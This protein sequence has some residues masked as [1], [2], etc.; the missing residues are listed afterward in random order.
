MRRLE[1]IDFRNY[2]HLRLDLPDAPV[3]L[4]GA[5]GA[6]KTNL[7]EALSLFSPGRGLRRVLLREL[8][9][10][11]AEAGWTLSMRLQT[12]TGEVRLGTGLA[13]VD[14]R[15]TRV[16]RCDG[17]KLSAQG[18]AE[19]VGLQWLTP[20]MDRLFIEG[21]APRR[22]YLDRLVLAF[23][24][25]HGRRVASYERGLRERAR[26]ARSGPAD[27]TWLKVLEERMAGDA[28]AI[29]AARRDAVAR[30]GAELERAH[31]PF[32]GAVLEAR[33]TIE[34]W[35]DQMAAVDAEARFQDSLAAERARGAEHAHAADG[36]QRS[37]LAVYHA[38]KGVTAAQC[39]TGEQKA[40]LIAIQLAT[41]RLERRRRGQPPILLFDEIAAHLDAERRAALFDSLFTLGGQVWMTGTDAELFAPLAGRAVFGRVD[42]G[43]IELDDLRY[44][45][46]QTSQFGQTDGTWRTESFE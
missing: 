12:G 40:L 2:R 39:S 1:L 45:T 33:G 21:P 25:M 43:R 13:E 44:E 19:I 30:L 17:D 28:V 27:P 37:D 3:V 38:R 22:R 10:Y 15:A 42:D 11:G 31:G 41:A 35:L 46:D 5:N 18:L 36:P 9:R 26:L 23:D 29:A 20:Q 6:G 4:V 32:P 16:V 7:L 14:G 8:T 24:P 34:G